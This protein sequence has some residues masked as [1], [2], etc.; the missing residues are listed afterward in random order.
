MVSWTAKQCFKI[1][2]TEN[3][4]KTERQKDK[5]TKRQ[6]DRETER[7]NDKKTERQK[8]SEICHLKT[9]NQN[10]FVFEM[11]IQFK[12]Y[13]LEKAK[14]KREKLTSRDRN[15]YNKVRHIIIINVLFR[16]LKLVT[17]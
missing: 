9:D 8:D 7:P 14:T 6:K 3:D 13:I 10:L 11:E 2:E 15:S 16:M 1:R 12:R 4:K 17:S 5:K